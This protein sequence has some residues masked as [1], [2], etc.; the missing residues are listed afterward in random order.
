MATTT[1]SSRGCSMRKFANRGTTMRR[2]LVM[3][4]IARWMLAGCASE[5]SRPP[6]CFHANESV[7]NDIGFCQAFRDGDTL[8]ISGTAGQGDMAEAV[9]SV[10]QPLEKTLKANGLSFAD[11]VKENVYAT[12]LDAFIRHKDIRK[13]FYGRSFPAATWVEVRRLYLPS[14][15]VEIEL[16]A[17]NLK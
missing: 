4:V 10:Y 13:E 3:T 15:V 8:R 7:E 11:V 17:K 14:F 1:M 2:V 5:P 16:T 9:R 6:R 12:D